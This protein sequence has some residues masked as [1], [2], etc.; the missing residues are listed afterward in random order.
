ML[1]P[2]SETEGETVIFSRGGGGGGRHAAEDPRRS[3][4]HS[5]DRQTDEINEGDFN[6]ADFDSPSRN[7]AGHGGASR[8]SAS[9]GS[10]SHD[11]ASDDRASH[12]R[13]GRDGVSGTGSAASGARHD[14]YTGPYDISEAPVGQIRVDLGSL[15][16]PSIEGVEVRVQ[17]TDG[18][19]QQVVL[20]YGASALQLGAFAAPRTEGIWDE[21]RAEIRKSLFND[22]VA[23]EEVA[24]EFGTELRARVRAAEGMMDLRFIGIDGPRWML[25]AV[26][27]G[28]AA[29]DP[30][31]AG[32]LAL[33]L[34]GLVVDRGRE[35]MPVRDA[36]PLR[37]PREMA[38][39]VNAAQTQAELDQVQLNQ[40]P[41]IQP[42]QNQSAQNQLPQ[43]S[44]KPQPDLPTGPD[45]R[46]GGSASQSP[47]GNVYGAS[48]NSLG[49]DL[50]A[51][52][53]GAGGLGGGGLGGA[54]LGGG[55]LGSPGLPAGGFGSSS[56]TGSSNASSGNASPSNASSS[57][58]SST[59]GN[60]AGGSAPSNSL[61]GNSVHGNSVD[62][63]SMNGSSAGDH[64]SGSV[65]SGDAAPRRRP[66]PR[67]RRSE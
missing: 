38:E 67:P 11:S 5:A 10:A 26:Y 28:A 58:G 46:T 13:A 57:N 31:E 33:C 12:N 39:Q 2:V 36:L 16:I 47:Q 9:R 3:G 19:I 1:D 8:D 65:S 14:A 54:R 25:R 44:Q 29:A 52:D 37:L 48:V 32:P 59:S 4:R 27:Q 7:G 50:G 62:S 35:A 43:A 20:A 49:R 18:V 60:P 15:Q 24:G 56:M 42:P 21:V 53:L 23:A 64:A 6:D 30:S 61:Y 22:G 17:A 55:G 66:S 41:Q 63:T 40:P 51:G 34:R 45:L